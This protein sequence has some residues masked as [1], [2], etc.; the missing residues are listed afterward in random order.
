VPAL[1]LNALKLIFLAL[2][3]LF[4]WQ[5]GRSIG[6][7]IGPSQSVRKSKKGGELVVVRSDSAAGQR[8]PIGAPAVL[9][10]SEDADIYIDD[11]YAS[12]FHVRI[13]IQDDSVVLNDLGST[14]GTYVNGRRVTVPTTLQKGDAVQ[15][16]K[17]ILE[18][19]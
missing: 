19:R 8:F 4:L 9:G 6:A 11:A 17:T 7:H 13:G 14:N 15:I 3:Y 18:V 1:F 16:G 5:I 10:R 2:I 12:E